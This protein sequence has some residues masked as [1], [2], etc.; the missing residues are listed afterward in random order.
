MSDT[1]PAERISRTCDV[2]GVEDTHAHHVQHVA[3]NH[4]VTGEPTDLSVSRHIQCCAASGCPICATDVEY[5]AQGNVTAEPS[6]AFTAYMTSKADDHA[7]ALFEAH[8]VETPK[9]NI[10]A[11]QT[12]ES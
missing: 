5:A 9:F 11:T 2:C 4:P 10:P 1:P 8:G 3:F 7:Q 6:D 12:Q